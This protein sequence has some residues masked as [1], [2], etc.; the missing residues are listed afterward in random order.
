MGTTRPC[1]IACAAW[2]GA[3]AA[4]A[5]SEPRSATPAL[6]SPTVAVVA[7]VDSGPVEPSFD[8]GALDRK[9]DPCVDFYDFACGG[10]RATHPIP[11]DRSRWTRQAEMGARN[12]ERE[13]AIVEKAATA[14]PTA[15]ASERRVGTY[16]AACMDEAA[17]ETLGQAPIRD[18]LAAIDAMATPADLA[19]VVANLHTR[20]RFVLFDV[21]VESDP[22]DSSRQGASIHSG[23]LG[24]GDSEDYRRADDKSAQ[25]RDKY[26]AHVASVLRLLGAADA[27][28]DADR[29]LALETRLAGSL[30]PPAERRDAE[31]H[32]HPMTLDELVARAPAFDWRIYFQKMGT[33]NPGRMNVPFPAW[34]EAMNAALATGDLADVR[35]YLRYQVANGLKAL[36]PRAIDEAFFDF[37]QRTR[38]GTQ[39]EAPRTKRCIELV[40]RDLGDDVGRMFVAH[41][42]PASSRDRVAAMVRAIAATFR[43]ELGENDWLSPAAR[44]AAVRKLDNHRFTVGYP[45]HWKDYDSLVVRRDD[46]ASNAEN[47][48]AMEVARELARLGH[49]T[50]RDEFSEL[51]QEVDA[52]GTKSLVSTGFTAGFLQPP[53]FDPRADDA[54]T[55]GGLGG[56]VGHELTHHFDDEGRKY[57]VDGNVRP[58]WS[59]EDMARY[60]ERARCIAD[61]Y[62][63]FHIEDGTPV[64]GKLTLGENI[65]DNGGV[66]LAWDTARPSTTGPRIDGFTPAQR[67]FLGWSQNR[68]EN[69][70]PEASRVL[71][72]ANPHAPGRFRVDGVVSNMPEFATAFACPAGAPMAPAARCR[73]W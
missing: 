36:L 26:R 47:A 41:Y 43:A 7:A 55:F 18:F 52:F 21:S 23:A 61:E 45:A 34:I 73:V 56:V 39:A 68:C 28:S 44:E 60:E 48:R 38:Q 63:H 40:D 35:A 22:H 16:Y 10:W 58:W 67:F 37:Q 15:S 42:F 30:P 66:R 46:P 25:L 17:I 12:A 33:P 50:D 29:V 13:R 19:A 3:L 24:L 62:S 6:S 71:I 14:G 70:T 53:V 65:A 69:V 9:V 31:S 20:V 49:P 54:V 8:G 1:S 72:R 51:A 27:A 64:D 2:F 32:I 5:G 59:P 11:P 4:C 57:D